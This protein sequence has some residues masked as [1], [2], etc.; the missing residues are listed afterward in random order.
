MA[1]LGNSLVTVCVCVRGGGGEAST[2]IEQK[3]K[4][5]TRDLQSHTAVR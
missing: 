5:V 4:E 1:D 2:D 3:G